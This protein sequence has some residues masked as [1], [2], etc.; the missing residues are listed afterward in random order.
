ALARALG[1]ARDAQ[2]R[3]T[4]GLALCRFG[5]AAAAAVPALTAAL[6]DENRYVRAHAAEALRYIGT[7]E[8][9]DA[10]LQELTYVRWCPTTTKDN[11]FYP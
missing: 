2:T 9:R 1:D 7:P 8:A 10:L 11:T 4:A 5:A 6:D 3:F